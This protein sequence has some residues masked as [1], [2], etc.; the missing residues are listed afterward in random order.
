MNKPPLTYSEETLETLIRLSR[1]LAA[2]AFRHLSTSSLP[3]VGDILEEEETPD[4]QLE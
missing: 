4:M 1:I 2:A 3:P